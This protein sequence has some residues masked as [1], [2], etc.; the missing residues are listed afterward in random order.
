M[1]KKWDSH[2]PKGLK[3]KG[4]KWSIRLE[5]SKHGIFRLGPFDDM[6][7]AQKVHDFIVHKLGLGKRASPVYLESQLVGTKVHKFCEGMKDEKFMKLLKN[8]EFYPAYM[9]FV[10]DGANKVGNVVGAEDFVLDGA[11]KVG[12]VV[13]AEDFVLDA[14]NKVGEVVVTEDFVLDGAKTP[15]CSQKQ[16]IAKH[17]M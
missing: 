2:A 8:N 1:S 13:G 7:E 16:T 11:N 17:A 15:T 12:N 5:A 4:D 6:D 10:L 3:V 14:A 9:N